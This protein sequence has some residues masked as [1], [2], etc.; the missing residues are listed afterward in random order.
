MRQRFLE[1]TNT[2][3]KTLAKSLPLWRA[4]HARFVATVGAEYWLKL[5]GELEGLARTTL[6]MVPESSKESPSV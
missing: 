5:R 3:E 1:V 2:G 4:A 6:E